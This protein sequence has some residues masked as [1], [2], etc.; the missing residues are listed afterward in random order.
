MTNYEQVVCRICGCKLSLINNSHLRSHNITREE[1]EERFPDAEVASRE[2]RDHYSAIKP[3]EETRCKMSDAQKGRNL[4]KTYEEIFGEERAREIRDK[5][6]HSLRE[7]LATREPTTWHHT[8]EA[9]Q[10]ISEAGL[11]RQRTDEHRRRISESLSAFYN[12]DEGKQKVLRSLGKTYEEMYGEERAR[13]IKDKQSHSLR[14]TFAT[15]EPVTWHHTE[16]AK[17]KISEASEGRRWTDEQRQRH[18][19]VLSA[20]YSTEEGRQLA[21]DNSSRPKP[22]EAYREAAI[23]RWQDPEYVE[24]MCKAFDMKPNTLE[25]E[26]DAI[27]RKYF[28]DEWKYVGDGQVWLDGK[29]PDFI[30]V[31]G[32]KLIIELFGDYWH[33]EEDVETRTRH[34]KRF[35][36]DTLVIWEHDMWESEEDISCRVEEFVRA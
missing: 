1:Y 22:S 16:E 6:S 7:A 9:K 20:F 15:R 11:G 25:L 36:F 17:R 10:K 34:F 13:E 5:Q 32:K 28:P 24:M 8:E 19:T 26:L 27:L 29:N 2:L 4:G 35:G 30:N 33:T 18:S 23:R 3:T 31:N 21:A 12:T 14:E